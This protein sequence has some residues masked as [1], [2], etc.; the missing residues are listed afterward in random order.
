MFGRIIL[1]KMSSGGHGSSYGPVLKRRTFDEFPVPQ[2]S[3]QEAYNAK[4]NK[5]NAVLAFGVACLGGTIA[6][7]VKTD[8]FNVEMVFGPRK[9]MHNPPAFESPVLEPNILLEYQN[10]NQVQPVAV[11]TAKK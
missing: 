4:Q 3:W 7:I 5:E 11:A 6:Y 2:G 10:Q 9:F 8:P 1:R